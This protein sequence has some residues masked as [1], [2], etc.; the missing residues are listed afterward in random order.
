MQ[1][2]IYVCMLID[3]KLLK[4]ESFCTKSS[5]EMGILNEG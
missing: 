5:V 3:I 4:N 1:R 2:A